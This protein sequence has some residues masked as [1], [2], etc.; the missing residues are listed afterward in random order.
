MRVER[1]AQ[2]EYTGQSS[3]EERTAQIVPKGCRDPRPRRVEERTDDDH[4]RLRKPSKKAGERPPKRIK[5]NSI[6][7]YAGLGIL[8]VPISQTRKVQ[9]PQALVGVCRRALPVL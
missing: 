1:T 8:P 4:R 5:R 6:Q 7:H 3:Q 2:Q 9:N